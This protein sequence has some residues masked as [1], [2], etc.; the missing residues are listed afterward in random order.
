MT[1]ETKPALPDPFTGINGRL[2]LRMVAD[3]IRPDELQRVVC[4]R[5]YFPANMPVRDYP[6]E[7]V[8][9]W[10]L[11]HWGEILGLVAAN[12]KRDEFDRLLGQLDD[13]GKWQ[14]LA[15]MRQLAGEK[16]TNSTRTLAAVRGLC[17]DCLHGGPCCDYSENRRCP[18][19]RPDGSCWRKGAKA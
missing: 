17:C 4:D 6:Q 14:L 19:R 13:S 15:F 16:G 1:H 5:G 3:R 18:H 8:T 2:I 12:R 7:F 9:G 10:C 11:P